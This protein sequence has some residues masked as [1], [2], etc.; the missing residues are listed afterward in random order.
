ME[1]LGNAEE[2]AKVR[3]TAVD[4]Y[5]EEYNFSAHLRCDDTPEIVIAMKAHAC[6]PR[7]SLKT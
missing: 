3:N 4:K 2:E 1:Y 5:A 7:I 6:V